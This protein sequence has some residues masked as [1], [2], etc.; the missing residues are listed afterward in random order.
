[1]KAW[2]PLGFETYTNHYP[3]TTLPR[4]AAVRDCTASFVEVWQG[5]ADAWSLTLS[6]LSK[7]LA[8]TTVI[9]CRGFLGNCMPGNFTAPLKAVEALGCDV[10]L[11]A[12]KT[13]HPIQTNV[14][15]LKKHLEAGLTTPRFVLCAHSRAGIEC[16]EFLDQHPEWRERC[17]ALLMAQT[18]RGPSWVLRSLYAKN[19]KA[20]AL[21]LRRRSAEALQR[22][23]LLALRAASAARELADPRWDSDAFIQ[24][25]SS[26]AF[27]IWQMASWSMQATSWLDS[28]HERLSAM[29]PQVAHDGQFLLHDLLWPHLPH[30][31]LPRLDHA[32]PVM[33]GHGFDPA[34]FWL[35]YLATVLR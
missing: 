26:Y 18:S 33:G 35:A 8:D 3:Q 23:G 27:P 1:M 6:A 7:Q 30:L 14:H 13:Q 19:H 15:R 11:A 24:R 12:L 31:L 32:Q 22:L 21:P 4:L 16:L 10:S 28:Y 20:R 9:F 34:R 5:E 29:H 2:T 25:A 17:R